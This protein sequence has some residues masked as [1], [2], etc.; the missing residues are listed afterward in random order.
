M[1]AVTVSTTALDSFATDLV[2]AL[3]APPEIA[4][5]VA[6]SLVDADAR[7]HRSHGV[8]RIP[9]YAEMIEAGELDP[10]AT[11]TV[12]HDD[13]ATSLVDGRF[14]FGQ[15]VGREAVDV[16]VEKALNA[17][18]AAV[19]VGDATHLGR[20][21]EW[22]ERA[23]AAGVAFVAFVNT[24]GGAVTVAPPGSADRRLSTNP[25]A[26]GVPTFDALEYP[27]VLDAATSQVAHGKVKEKVATGEALPEDWAVTEDGRPVTDASAF[28]AGAG[29][30]LPL[31]G[32]A[33]GYKGFGLA[34]VAELLAG[35]AGDALVAGQR[36]SPWPRNAAAFFALDPLR[37]TTHEGIE[38]RVRA[39]VDH[40]QSARP[41]DDLDPGDGAAG[42]GWLLP[43]EAEHRAAETAREAGVEVPVRVA[44][45]LRTLAEERGVGDAVPAS[46]R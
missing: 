46:L 18:V 40:L 24:Q 25:V 11:P 42:D 29:A 5:A 12:C 28:V 45:S 7:G 26:V 30:L 15:V 4:E 23:S 44:A 22:A 9:W 10:G 36:E 20:I 17:G 8:I 35:I 6:A 39:L 2:G 33:S 13:A 27:L 37:F 34:V 16:A 19:G 14:A 31:G 38:A 32:R 43:G 3:G 41:A 21:G 1:D